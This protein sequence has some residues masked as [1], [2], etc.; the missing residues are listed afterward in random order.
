M[1][2]NDQ[3]EQRL[4]RQPIRQLPAHWREDILSVA[5]AGSPH[6]STEDFRP[7]GW[8][9]TLNAQLAT[10]LWPRPKAWAG[11]AALW[12][13]ILGVN[14]ATRGTSPTLEARPVT[15]ISPDTLWL[16]KQ[17]EQLLAEMS[18]G[19]E[20]REAGR[21]KAAPPRPRTERRNE[22]LNS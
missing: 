3:F 13:V 12:L 11:L 19:F 18:G 14:F 10:L 15:P 17:R 5:R 7:L 2:Q 16:L 8:L 21:P 1:N 22:Q 4:Q 20:P 6:P 9:S